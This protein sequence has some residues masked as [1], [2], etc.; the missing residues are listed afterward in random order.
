MIYYVKINKERK[1]PAR[2]IKEKVVELLPKRKPGR[3]KKV[4]DP[5]VEAIKPK[6]GKD[7]RV[8]ENIL[9]AGIVESR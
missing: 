7:I 2:I 1:T 4:V 9:P 8:K 5:F 6:K 3:P